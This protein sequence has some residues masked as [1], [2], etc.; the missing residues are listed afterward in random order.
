VH[1]LPKGRLFPLTR[2]ELVESA[3]LFRAVR[4]GELDR[5]VITE[6]SLD[7]LAQQVVAESA[8][9]DWDVD[10][11]MALVRRSRPYA[12]LSREEFDGVVRM[13]SE[14]YVT[15]RG[16]RAA[17]VH[18]DAVNG[19]IRGR[20]GARLLALTSGGAIPDNADYRV[21]LEPE[22]TFI[23]TVNEDFA[24]ESMAG[25]V[26][27]LGATSWR[28][29]RIERGVV[30]VADAHG[31]PPSLPFWLG[32]AP[33][34]SAELS[35]GVAVLRRELDERLDDPEDSIAGLVAECGISRLAAAQVV[36]YLGEAR[37]LLDDTDA[38]SDPKNWWRWLPPGSPGC[39]IGSSAR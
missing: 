35:L 19:Q 1:G 27:Q 31:E 36:E 7:V 15:R 5:V 17:L 33:T 12:D 20:R 39:T 3:A 37:R 21:V 16:R 4:R 9:E 22:G 11:L 38:I 30:R 2:D 28:I 13:V 6:R 10:A 25:D 23:G 29:L 34:R 24:V 18:H 8:A 32:E 26:F 14:G